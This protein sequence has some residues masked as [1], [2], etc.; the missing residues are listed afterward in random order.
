MEY[1]EQFTGRASVEK[2]ET[3]GL[4]NSTAWKSGLVR[5]GRN[6]LMAIGENTCF[7]ATICQKCATGSTVEDPNFMNELRGLRGRIGIVMEV[8]LPIGGWLRKSEVGEHG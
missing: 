4:S 6:T 1:A 2:R 7:H 8:R 5:R 3:F